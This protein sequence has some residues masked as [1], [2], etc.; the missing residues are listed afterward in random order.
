MFFETLSTF[1]QTVGSLQQTS[2]AAKA[3]SYNSRISTYNAEVTEQQGEIAET[4]VRQ[5]SRRRIGSIRANVGAS[6]LSLEGSPEDVLGES[7]YNAEI[8]ALNTR[9]NFGVKATEHR[10]QAGLQKTRARSTRIG[11]Y[12]S[13]SGILLSGL[14]RQR[15][16][17]AVVEAA[18]TQPFRIGG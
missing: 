10:M 17:G 12:L 6:G 5:D 15:K 13:A 8:N 7:A 4:Q 1:F 3:F 14:A 2:A 11:G 9:Y 18:G 16:R